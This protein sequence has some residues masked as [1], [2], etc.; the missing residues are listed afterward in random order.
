[1]WPLTVYEIPMTKVEKL[2]RTVSSYI[3]KWLGLPRCLSN[4]GL[5]GHGA[6]ELPVSSL[7][8]E[9]K[10]TKVRLN[11]TLTESQD[12]MIQRLP[13]DWQLG[14]SGCHLRLYSKQN[15]LS[16]METL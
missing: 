2:E 14:G 3:K 16:G 5:Y 11:M 9:Y 8:E 10:C 1:M 13:P 12:G 7:T 15:L 6:L 4:I